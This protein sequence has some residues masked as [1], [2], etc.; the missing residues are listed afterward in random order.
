MLTAGFVRFDPAFQHGRLCGSFPT[1]GEL[2]DVLEQIDTDGT[3]AGVGHGT[4]KPIV[5]R[6]KLVLEVNRPFIPPDHLRFH[7]VRFE[8][9]Q[10]PPVAHHT[11]ALQQ[12]LRVPERPEAGP[13]VPVEPAEVELA[14]VAPVV[15][16]VQQE[17]DILR[18]A[19]AY[20]CVLVRDLDCAREQHHVQHGGQYP[21]EVVHI[22]QCVQQCHTG[23]Q[24]PHCFALQ[25]KRCYETVRTHRRM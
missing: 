20:D 14:Q 25:K 5:Q 7:L 23:R 10:H 17:I 8:D 22:A 4:D 19:E 1:L 16:V 9:G 6:D 13:A 2:L 12:I 3:L 11:F 24:R 18:C 15:H 21:Y